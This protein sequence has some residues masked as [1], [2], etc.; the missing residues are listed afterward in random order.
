VKFD[1]A[2]MAK[3]QSAVVRD[4]RS[5]A[6]GTDLQ[7]VE[8]KYANGNRLILASSE[9]GKLPPRAEPPKT[10][11][12]VLKVTFGISTPEIYQDAPDRTKE[13]QSPASNYLLLLDGAGKHID[14]HKT[15][16]DRVFAWRD[17]A[18]QLHLY[19]VGYERIMFVGHLTMPLPKQATT[20]A[21]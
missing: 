14:N 16:I 8:I 13:F 15:G 17:S 1:I 21:W 18:D 5:T 12:D 11:K 7:E 9:L 4:V 10:E 6:A 3:A 20:S 2:W 19:L